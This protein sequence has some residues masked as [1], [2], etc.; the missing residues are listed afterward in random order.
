MEKYSDKPFQ[1]E[2]KTPEEVIIYYEWQCNC[3]FS[4]DQEVDRERNNLIKLSVL[5]G[6]LKLSLIYY[7]FDII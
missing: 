6:I 5:I 1:R 3:K 2:K 7:W 4:K